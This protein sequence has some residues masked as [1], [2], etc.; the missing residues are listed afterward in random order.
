MALRHVDECTPGGVVV[1]ADDDRVAGPGVDQRDLRAED[2][3]ISQRAAA[4]SHGT[5]RVSGLAISKWDHRP[6]RQRSAKYPLRTR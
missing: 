6:P 2:V 1:R 4:A 3:E 5:D